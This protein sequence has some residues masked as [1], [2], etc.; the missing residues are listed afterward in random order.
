MK[1]LVAVLLTLVL[2]LSAV[3]ALADTLSI[4]ATPN[5]HAE[6]L[7]LVREDLAALG[8]ELNL[9]ISDNYVVENPSTALCAVPLPLGKGGFLGSV[10]SP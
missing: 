7:E 4:I 9:E 5:P 1:K 3:A 6:I 8:Y 10:S 2:S